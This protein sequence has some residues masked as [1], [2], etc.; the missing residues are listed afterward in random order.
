MAALVLGMIALA[1]MRLLGI[2]GPLFDREDKVFWT[3]VGL[4]GLWGPA[5]WLDHVIET[6]RTGGAR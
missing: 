2:S 4:G 5:H 1:F 6:E 3:I